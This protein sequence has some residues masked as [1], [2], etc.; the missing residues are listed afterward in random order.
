MRYKV[1]IPSV[2][3]WGDAVVLGVSWGIYALVVTKCSP[4]P[5]FYLGPDPEAVLLTWWHGIGFD[6]R[7][8]AVLL[9]SCAGSLAAL[10]VAICLSLHFWGTTPPKDRRRLLVTTPLAGLVCAGTLVGARLL[11]FF[12]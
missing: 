3:R 2:P 8:W 9:F 5:L 12:G 4:P 11:P 1:S 10:A 6:Y 7:A